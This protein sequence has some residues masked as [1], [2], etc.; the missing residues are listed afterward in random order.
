MYESPLETVKYHENVKNYYYEEVENMYTLQ[1]LVSFIQGHVCSLRQ[2]FSTSGMLTFGA[3]N[4]SSRRTVPC[5]VG[6]LAASLA[7]TRW[8][9][10]APIL[11]TPLPGL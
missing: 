1:R 6:R 4:Y 7:S 8:M 11:P 3:G 9:P 5:M 2:G 10:V